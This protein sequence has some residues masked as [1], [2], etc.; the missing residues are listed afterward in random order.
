MDAWRAEGG[1]GGGR[2]GGGGGGGGD[3][4]GGGGGGEGHNKTLELLH[5]RQLAKEL[6][7]V[8][9]LSHPPTYHSVF[10]LIH[11]PTY[12]PPTVAHS[13]RLL[14]LYL[15]ITHPPTHNRRTKRSGAYSATG[16]KFPSNKAGSV[17]YTSFSTASRKT[18]RWMRATS[19]PD[20]K[21]HPP[22]HPPTHLRFV[23]DTPA[24]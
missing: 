21:P 5:A 4:G 15:P 11:L 10:S 18:R 23:E 20:C 1:G 17:A 14:L 16:P 6:E 12:R 3:R 9:V 8:E 7:I 13:N 24:Y 19:P 22:T 2:R